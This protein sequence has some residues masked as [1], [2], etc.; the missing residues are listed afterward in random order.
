MSSDEPAPSG[1]VLAAIGVGTAPGGYAADPD[2]QD[3]L[4]ALRDFLQRRF[5]NES[6]F[7]RCHGAVGINETPCTT[8]TESALS[9][10]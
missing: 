3:R 4:K 7:N 5:E 9:H 2:L 10:H 1:A 8:D 6:L